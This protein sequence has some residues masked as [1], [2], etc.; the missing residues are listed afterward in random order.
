MQ[1]YYVQITDGPEQLRPELLVLGVRARHR[2]RP[3]L[4]AHVADA[5]APHARTSP[6]T[7]SVEYDVN[8]EQIRS[9]GV[10]G[11]LRCPAWR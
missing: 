10:Y 7:S 9:T 4:P 2:A 11:N 1:T 8:F 5:V 6:S 3:P